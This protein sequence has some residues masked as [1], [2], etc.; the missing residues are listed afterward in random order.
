LIWLYLENKTDFFTKSLKMLHIAPEI[1]FIPR[2]EEMEN[3]E[4]I[5]GDLES[6][7]AK[8]KL[9]IHSLPFDDNTFDVVFCNHV[10]EH[11]DDDRKA[12]REIHR[13]LKPGGWAILQIPFFFPLKDKTIE[14]PSVKS[15]SERERFFGQSDHVRMYGKD[16]G[17][18]LKSEGFD[19]DASKF[20]Q[21]FSY[22]DVKKYGLPR[23]E[24]LYIVN[25]PVHS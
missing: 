3:L 20:A 6:P 11:V 17:D 4:Y 24:I 16:Y 19:V 23:E 13:T 21:T 12:M 14:D 22:E 1:C 9:D 8:V 25:K 15:P 18:R 7:L 2:F 10:L 5:T